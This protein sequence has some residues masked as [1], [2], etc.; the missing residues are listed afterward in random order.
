MAPFNSRTSSGN[1]LTTIL[2]DGSGVAPQL[3]F[4]PGAESLLNS[5]NT[6]NGLAADGSDN[7]YLSD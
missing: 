3:N 7:V 4:L 6:I 1:V 5:G 2:I